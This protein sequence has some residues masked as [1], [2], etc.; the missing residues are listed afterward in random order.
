MEHFQEGN[1]VEIQGIE[2]EVDLHLEVDE[3]D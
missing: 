1:L 3:L 2:N